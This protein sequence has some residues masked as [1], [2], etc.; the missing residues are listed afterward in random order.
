MSAPKSLTPEKYAAVRQ[1]HAERGYTKEAV[2]RFAE[3]YPEHCQRRGN[4]KP[5][6]AVP[7]LRQALRL[8]R[9]GKGKQR[10]ARAGLIQHDGFPVD[11]KIFDIEIPADA[12]NPEPFTIRILK[13][14][15]T[16]FPQ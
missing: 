3:R 7:R 12:W 4:G 1:R 16:Y 9:E 11:R 8:A 13:T 5:I 15:A 10:P 6:G 2:D 14:R